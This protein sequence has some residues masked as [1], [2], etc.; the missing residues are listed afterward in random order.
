MRR[1]R[2]PRSSFSTF[3]FSITLLRLMGSHIGV[4]II[5]TLLVSSPWHYSSYRWP[6]TL[7]YVEEGE[8]IFYQKSRLITP[9]QVY[10]VLLKTCM[11]HRGRP[12]SGHSY[13]FR[14]LA[15]VALYRDA[16]TKRGGCR[17]VQYLCDDAYGK[18]LE[19][20]DNV[21]RVLEERLEEIGEAGCGEPGEC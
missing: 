5:S 7:F 21:V 15:L 6:P 17:P 12:S 1:P 18:R 3:P 14:D 20:T 16:A 13:P 11:R 19:S 2:S 10:L 8:S 9:T 4:S